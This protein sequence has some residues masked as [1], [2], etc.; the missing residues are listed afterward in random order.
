MPTKKKKPIDALSLEARKLRARLETEWRISDAAGQLALLTLCQCV[1]RLRQAQ[2]VL[3]ADGIT[4]TDR[5]GKLK[6]HPATVIERE[7]RAGMFASLK[8]LNLDVESL[9]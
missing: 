3:A 7:A 9:D 8:A 4:A 5:F 2:A 1:D 6:V